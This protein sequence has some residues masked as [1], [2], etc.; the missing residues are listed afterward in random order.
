MHLLT[1][2]IDLL[3][4][5]VVAIYCLNSILFACFVYVDVPI[6]PDQLLCFIMLF[7]SIF[8][9]IGLSGTHCY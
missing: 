3:S 4:A 8:C 6:D 9:R 1:F 2:P 5:V 7:I